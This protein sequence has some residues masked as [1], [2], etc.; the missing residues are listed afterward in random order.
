MPKATVSLAKWYALHRVK[1]FLKGHGLDRAQREAVMKVL[2]WLVN[3]RFIPIGLG[4]RLP[5][6]LLI[7]NSLRCIAGVVFPG[8]PCAP[9]PGQALVSGLMGT[10]L[11]GLARRDQKVIGK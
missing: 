4:T 11:I 3:L 8:I 6:W 1:K 9:D 7:A 2:D 5:A 10:G